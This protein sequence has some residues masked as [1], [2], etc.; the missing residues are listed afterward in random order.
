MA[1]ATSRI[2]LDTPSSVIDLPPMVNPHALP[3]THARVPDL[4][5]AVDALA[6]RVSS[7]SQRAA[8]VSR[9]TPVP[10]LLEA[11]PAPPSH[12]PT[13]LTPGAILNSPLLAS[14]TGLLASTS[15]GP[16][17]STSPTS[18]S[19]VKSPC[20]PR[21]IA[22]MLFPHNNPPPSSPPTGPLPPIPGPSSV[23]PDLI[24]THRALQTAARSVSPTLSMAESQRSQSRTEQRPRLSID[25]NGPVR[26][27]GRQGSLSSLRN[28][29]YP[30]G[31][32]SATI[33]EELMGKGCLAPPPPSTAPQS[34]PISGSVAVR[35]SHD[36]PSRGDS[37]D[38]LRSCLSR[39]A[40]V[41]VPRAD[42]KLYVEDSIANVDMSDLNAFK[43]DNEGDADDQ[44]SHRFPRSPPLPRSPTQSP[45]C[46]P[47]YPPSYTHTP[48]KASRSSVSSIHVS[49]NSEDMRSRHGALSPEITQM[50][51][52]APRPRK[53]STPSQSREL[54]TTRYRK[55]SVGGRK[56]VDGVPSSQTVKTSL[57]R[58]ARSGGG[59]D[60]NNIAREDEGHDSDSSLDLH[61]P[62]P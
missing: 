17:V 3:N 38:V 59:D 1:I 27:R 58:A 6:R 31:E 9:R 21:L 60:V 13:N 18:P 55:G 48:H 4:A 20:S 62:L 10:F 37:P 32:Q 50:I 57:A 11:F 36:R 39:V 33:A 54:N 26:G 19:N 42:D 2:S 15:A 52:A 47:T 16:A 7:E 30:V 24:A 43:S 5:P 14:A 51:S 40:A 22:T 53:R 45:T 34:L 46:P 35:R 25:V 28:P 29:I 8:R 41:P 12:I 23:T 61:T 44:A 49:Q 56:R